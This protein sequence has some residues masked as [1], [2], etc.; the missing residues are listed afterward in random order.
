MIAFTTG[1]IFGV[2]VGIVATCLIGYG[3]SKSVGDGSTKR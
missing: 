1:F 2:A 3:I